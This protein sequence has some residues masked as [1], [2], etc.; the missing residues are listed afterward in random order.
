MKKRK[1]I[2]RKI[3]GID[4]ERT[5]DQAGKPVWA[6]KHIFLDNGT[7]LT[8]SVVELGH[9]YAIEGIVFNPHF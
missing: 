6:I 8:F 4:Q 3:V 2:G 5:T 1:V 7:V 9:E